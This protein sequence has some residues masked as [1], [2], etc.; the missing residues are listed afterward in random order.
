[1]PVGSFCVPAILKDWP[2][3][4][5]VAFSGVEHSE[6]SA[7]RANTKDSSID[8][9]SYSLH[10]CHEGER[11]KIFL[12]VDSWKYDKSGRG[13]DLPVL[14]IVFDALRFK[15][16]AKALDSIKVMAR[17]VNLTEKVA[18]RVVNAAL[19]LINQINAEQVPDFERVL[20]LHRIH[21]DAARNVGGG[22]S[23][24]NEKLTKSS[25]AKIAV[26]RKLGSAGNDD[27]AS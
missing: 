24:R 11:E 5:W 26:R 9:L 13:V 10:H 16:P 14:E 27:N 17:P 19:F 12:R 7:T 25:P 8:G 2:S 6:R 20:E 23:I 15:N 1:M 18:T 22:V 21:P 3:R 4:G